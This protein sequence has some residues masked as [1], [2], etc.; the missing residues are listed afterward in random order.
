MEVLE[1]VREKRMVTHN[2]LYRNWEAQYSFTRDKHHTTLT[3][4]RVLSIAIV[5]PCNHLGPH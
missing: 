2:L 4:V 1:N 3:A 5:P